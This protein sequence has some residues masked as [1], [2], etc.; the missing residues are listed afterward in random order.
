MLMFCQRISPQQIPDRTFNKA[1][2]FSE[3]DSE[4]K[5]KLPTLSAFIK[6]E[7]QSVEQW[8]RDGGRFPS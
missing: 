8:V 6:S 1:N 7:N 4:T 3:G 5:W 2:A